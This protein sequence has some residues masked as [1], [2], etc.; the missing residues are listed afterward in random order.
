MT[1]PPNTGPVTLVTGGSSGIGAAVVRRLHTDGHRLAATYHRHGERA[2]ALTAD[3]DAH[4]TSLAF[5]P[6]DLADPDVPARLVQQALT[7]Y[8]R[9][10]HVVHCAA[11]IDTT[12]IEQTTS[13]SFDAVMR[14]NVTS[15]FLL[16]RA[17]ADQPTLRSTVTI[18]SIA[19]TFTGPDSAAYEASKAALSMLTRTMAA[20][21]APRV[22]INALAPGA[23][24]TERSL[25]DPGFPRAM[26]RQRIPLGRLATPADI[27]AT[28]AVLLGPDSSYITGQ[29]LI[30]DGGLS[31]KLT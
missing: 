6:A 1:R 25:A 31:L 17:A 12:P 9:L 22:R 2:A 29:V 13:S 20:A 18:S 7:R 16:L 26:L 5:W 23:V 21:Y 4:H 11:T 15:A 10:D 24:E 30:V 3:L 19:A 27:A 8:G 14:T 28:A